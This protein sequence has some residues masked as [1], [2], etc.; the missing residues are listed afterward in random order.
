MN[1]LQVGLRLVTWFCRIL[2][3]NFADV[4]LLFHYINFPFE[5]GAALRLNKQGCQ[6]G[7]KLAIVSEA[8]FFNNFFQC[9]LAISVLAPFGKRHGPLFKQT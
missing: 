6:D 1:K 8:D 9:T 7:L 3:S 4:F 5:K 2:F